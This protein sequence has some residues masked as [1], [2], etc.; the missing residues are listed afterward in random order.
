MNLPCQYTY[1]LVLIRNIS[2]SILMSICAYEYN[3]ENTYRYSYKYTYLQVCL[4]T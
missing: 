3:Y 4:C 2:S 1:K